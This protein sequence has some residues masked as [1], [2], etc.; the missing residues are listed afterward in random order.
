[1]NNRKDALRRVCPTCG[2]LAG[3]PCLGVSGPRKS[4]HRERFKGAFSV[5]RETEL[6][7]PPERNP[8]VEAMRESRSAPPRRSEKDYIRDAAG[9]ALERI[10]KRIS[11]HMETA[12]SYCESPIEKMLMVEIVGVHHADSL[13]YC[14]LFILGRYSDA[15]IDM[16]GAYVFPQA[17]VDGYR[18]DFLVVANWSDGRRYYVVEC[19]GH[20]Y[21]E[22]TK[23]QASHDKK[24]DRHFTLKGWNVLRY[25]GPDIWRDARSIAYEILNAAFASPDFEA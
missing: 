8:L 3:A 12:S 21:H 15:V 10:G 14:E 17:Q 2:V 9:Y 20:D 7:R 23:Q 24:R 11:R 16:P 13:L 4:V 5:P 19:D 6:V 18:I 1:M 22:R 25:T